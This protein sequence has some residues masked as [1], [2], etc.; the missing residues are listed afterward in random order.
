VQAQTI[1]DG[2]MSRIGM[3][4]EPLE[5]RRSLPKL[6]FFSLL[7]LPIMSVGPVFVIASHDA[8]KLGGEDWIFGVQPLWWLAVAVSAYAFWHFILLWRV[9]GAPGVI[10]RLSP[11]G[12]VMPSLGSQTPI[13]WRDVEARNPIGLSGIMG[14]IFELKI[15]PKA[16]TGLLGAAAALDDPAQGG[17]MIVRV[18]SVL[19]VSEKDILNTVSAYKADAV[20]PRPGA[21]TPKA[22]MPS[23][24]GLRSA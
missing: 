24:L 22:A 18:P 5:V 6:G 19:S 10:L 2:L 9:L 7:W 3:P 4:A 21:E 13:P 1:R 23:G 20:D 12:L 11:E 15:D 14:F 8:L 16:H 17:R